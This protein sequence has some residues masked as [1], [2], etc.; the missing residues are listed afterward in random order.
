MIYKKDE[1][2][3][4]PRYLNNKTIDKIVKNPSIKK[5]IIPRYYYKLMEK[6]N[7]NGLKRLLI[8]G[9]EIEV[10]N[11]RG[12]SK[13]INNTLKDKIIELYKSGYTILEISKQLNIAKSTVWDNCK[14]EFKRIIT[15]LHE[16]EEAEKKE[17]LKGLIYQ[18]KEVFIENDLYDASVKILFSEL[19]HAVEVGNLNRAYELLSELR[20]YIEHDE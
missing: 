16:K 18:Y 9:V 2:I 13:R 14:D 15:E 7:P 19:E 4:S 8:A 12:R 1:I 20:Y 11:K 5:I 10:R 3:Y 17:Q 6:K